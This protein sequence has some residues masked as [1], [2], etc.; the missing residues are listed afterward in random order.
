MVNEKLAG[1][2]KKT[3]HKNILYIKRRLVHLK[4]LFCSITDTYCVGQKLK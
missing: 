4:S 3:G 1:K 2:K